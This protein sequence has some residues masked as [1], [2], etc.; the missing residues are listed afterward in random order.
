MANFSRG[1]PRWA[2]LGLS[3]AMFCLMPP[4]FVA[5]GPDICL[6]R[7]LFHL[8]A[9]PACG[10]TRALCAFFHGQFAL[11]LSFNYNVLITAPATLLMLAKDALEEIRRRRKTHR[12][13][14][15]PRLQLVEFPLRIE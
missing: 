15:Q 2:V 1:L 5:R 11:A 13:Q 14:E 4:E 9:C 6:W 3:A 10:T 12:A 8:N 7:N